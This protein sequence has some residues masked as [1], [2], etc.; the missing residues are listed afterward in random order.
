MKTF[1]W[2]T[3]SWMSILF[4]EFKTVSFA[5]SHVECH[6]QPYGFCFSRSRTLMKN[7]RISSCLHGIAAPVAQDLHSSHSS[8]TFLFRLCC[9]L[10]IAPSLVSATVLFPVLVQIISSPGSFHLLCKQGRPE[11]PPTSETLLCDVFQAFSW[12]TSSNVEDVCLFKNVW[13]CC[14]LLSEKK[15]KCRRLCIYYRISYVWGGEK[16]CIR[17]CL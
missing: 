7:R 9:L 12:V 1:P 11:T 10:G 2:K 4:G 17:T 15:A 5:F 8:G 13:G 16:R 6:C 14:F 3:S